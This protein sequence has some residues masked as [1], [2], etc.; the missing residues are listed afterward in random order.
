MGSGKSIKFQREEME[1][2]RLFDTITG[3]VTL[4][5]VILPDGEDSERVIFMVNRQD[6]R[7]AVGKNGINVKKLKERL[8]KTIEIIAY[9]DDL[10]RF[11]GYLLYPAKITQITEQPRNDNKK[12]L[13]VSVRQEDKGLAIGKNGR[14]IEKANTLLRRHYP[15]IE[16]II[17]N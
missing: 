14:N 7:R 16:S 6:L 11:I 13:I 5:C 10:N 3:A 15:D 9:S 12:V 1:L 4:D 8:S 2:I 17:V